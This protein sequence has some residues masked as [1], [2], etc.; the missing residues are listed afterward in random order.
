ML[1]FKKKDHKN[2]KKNKLLI[3]MS[4]YFLS[5]LKVT[6]QQFNTKCAKPDASPM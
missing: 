2:V 5:I 6:T 1:L 4:I 3:D